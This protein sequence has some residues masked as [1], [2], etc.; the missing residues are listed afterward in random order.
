MDRLELA[1]QTYE[2]HTNIIYD[3]EIEHDLNLN[4]L[5]NF[6]STD[7]N[8]KHL[9]KVFFRKKI[10]KSF[11]RL[12]VL[13]K[14]Q[15]DAVSD[16]IE[17]YKDYKANNISIPKERKTKIQLLYDL[18]NITATLIEQSKFS[19]REINEVLR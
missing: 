7:L 6:I 2:F 14:K 12:L 4:S 10:N 15:M 16:L 5:R 11:N 3:F 8:P 13:Y 17:I 18:K 1:W 19:Q 9:K